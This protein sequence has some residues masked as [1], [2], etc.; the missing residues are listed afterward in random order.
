MDTSATEGRT[1][2]TIWKQDK[3]LGK[4]GYRFKWNCFHRCT[5]DQP[6]QVKPVLE[7]GHAL[8]SPEQL[9]CSDLT[10]NFSSW[11]AFQEQQPILGVPYPNHDKAQQFLHR[12]CLAGLYPV[13]VVSPSVYEPDILQGSQP[14]CRGKR[15]KYSSGLGWTEKEKFSCSILLH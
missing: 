1:L 2:S 8:S 13:L 15:K 14:C 6:K 12:G 3:T 7:Y 4:S 11:L 10:V 9:T 5:P